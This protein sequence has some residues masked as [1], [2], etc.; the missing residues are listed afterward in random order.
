M[1]EEDEEAE[2]SPLLPPWFF[3]L[4]GRKAKPYI[5]LR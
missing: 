4:Y 1:G 5:H 3:S 2:S